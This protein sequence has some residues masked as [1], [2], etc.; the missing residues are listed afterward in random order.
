M[1][2]ES[3]PSSN[4]TIPI[5]APEGLRAVQNDFVSD[6]QDQTFL[7]CSPKD[8]SVPFFMQV[9]FPDNRMPEA[10]D[11][12]PNIVVG[13]KTGLD[14]VAASTLIRRLG[15]SMERPSYRAWPTE[16]MIDDEST[17]LDD[18]LTAD[19]EVVGVIDDDMG[20][21]VEWVERNEDWRTPMIAVIT[22]RTIH[23]NAITKLIEETVAD[24][25]RENILG[26]LPAM[27]EFYRRYVEIEVRG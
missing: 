21:C 15:A 23:D 4:V 18:V 22:E 17:D 26:A 3:L 27:R 13:W 20:E 6:L 11:A 7:S 24:D 2:T 12:V 16:N 9:N 25:Q 14:R 8:M 1:N 19:S 5:A 10:S